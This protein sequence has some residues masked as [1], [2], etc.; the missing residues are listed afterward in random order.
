MKQEDKEREKKK[1]KDHV[2]RLRI[3]SYIIIL[4]RK[5]NIAIMSSR[6]HRNSSQTSEP[7]ARRDQQVKSQNKG[8][9]TCESP[10]KRYLGQDSSNSKRGRKRVKIRPVKD[11]VN[12]VEHQVQKVAFLSLPLFYIVFCFHPHLFILSIIRATKQIMFSSMK[13]YAVMYFNLS[14]TG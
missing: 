4:K 6:K 3:V 12:M 2:L 10:S 9:E 5:N 13:I 1:E 8:K 14:S 11:L 7:D